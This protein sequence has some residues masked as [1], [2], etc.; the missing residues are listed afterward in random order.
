MW[1]KIK[2]LIDNIQDTDEQVV[3]SRRKFLFTL[4]TLVA[5][6]KMIEPV[7]GESILSKVKYPYWEV[8][9]GTNLEILRYRDDLVELTSKAFILNVFG[10]NIVYRPSYIVL[11]AALSAG[12]SEALDEEYLKRKS[13]RS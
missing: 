6:P 1:K 12:T 8:P 13:D 7:W 11:K 10:S 2:Y 4:P 3:L 5:I 9:P